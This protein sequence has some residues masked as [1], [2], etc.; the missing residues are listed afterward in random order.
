MLGIALLV[1]GGV[2]G[3]VGWIG[4]RQKS[5]DNGPDPVTASGSP[6]TA[7]GSPP[8]AWRAPDRS[9]P[10]GRLNEVS[11]KARIADATMT[12]PP[13]PY[14]LSGDSIT[15]PDVIDAMFVAGAPVHPQYDGAHSWS[16][17]VGLA[18]LPGES[19]DS[20][21]PVEFADDRMGTVAERFFG[22]H[23]IKIKQARY[24]PLTVD[25][26]LCAEVTARIHYRIEDL[27]SRY[28]NFHLVGCPSADGG[29]VAA[30]SSVPDDA[31]PEV[32]RLAA[33]SVD[34]LELD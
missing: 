10:V 32:A 11:R 12:L 23:R 2:V 14:T 8:A 26:Q 1:G 3:T 29:I 33:A 21:D 31:D 18:H 22:D 30:I 6:S 4:D 13:D 16:A 9:G 34:S 28:D 15:V 5:A 7:E 24:A 17:T 25:G 27:A 20:A 19:V